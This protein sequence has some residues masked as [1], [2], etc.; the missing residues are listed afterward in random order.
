MLNPID[1]PYS[2]DAR[3]LIALSCVY[4]A[5]GRLK[6]DVSEWFAEMNVDMKE[7]AAVTGKGEPCAPKGRGACLDGWND[8][9][10]PDWRSGVD[11]E[12]GRAPLTVG[13]WCEMP[14]S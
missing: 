1:L 4:V 9:P 3:Y 10:V 7:V 2:A 6:R 5:A 8:C 14:V 13:G 11:S 12:C